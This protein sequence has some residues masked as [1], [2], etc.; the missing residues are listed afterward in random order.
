MR[1]IAFTGGRGNEGLSALMA[2]FGSLS[3]SLVLAECTFTYSRLL[4]LMKPEKVRTRYVPSIPRFRFDAERCSHCFKCLDI[5]KHE[6][7]LRHGDLIH[8]AEHRCTACG[9]CI[10]WCPLCVLDFEIDDNVTLSYAESRF[11]PLV[12][13]DS[14][15]DALHQPDMIA[16]LLEQA[17]Y[18]AISRSIGRL[19]IRLPRGN[20]EAASR[21][22]S[23]VDAIVIV[24]APYPYALADLKKQLVFCRGCGIRPMVILNKIHPSNMRIVE[25]LKTFC[26]L[27]GIPVAGEIP[28]DPL[29]PEAEQHGCSVIE[30]HQKSAI[31]QIIEETW[32]FIEMQLNQNS[33]Q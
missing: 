13:T 23:R 22:A 8:Y 26:M 20:S 4:R 21:A 29:F 17:H 5:C 3:G 14:I 1:T 10:R 30:Y 15:V 32:K 11:G 27:E 7:I 6:A 2:A 18:L 33:T 16:F 9:S 28:Y 19:H 25:E 12:Y 24:T 31:P